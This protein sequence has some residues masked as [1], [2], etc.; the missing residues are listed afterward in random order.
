M[1]MEKSDTL[2]RAAW[3]KARETTWGF[4]QS[5]GSRDPAA[6]VPVKSTATLDKLPMKNVKFLLLLL[7]NGCCKLGV[8]T[9]E[10]TGVGCKRDREREK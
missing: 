6:A 1:D 7:S 3:Q 8:A 4:T 2:H 5:A 9:I 10:E